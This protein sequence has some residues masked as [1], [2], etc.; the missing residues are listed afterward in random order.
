MVRGGTWGVTGW[1]GYL[2]V[3]EAADDAELVDRGPAGHAHR[4]DDHP[5]AQHR[6]RRPEPAKHVDASRGR[7]ERKKTTQYS[8]N[9]QFVPMSN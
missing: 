9:T 6:H 5:P 8:R 2:L 1:Y 4:G 7:R 3:A